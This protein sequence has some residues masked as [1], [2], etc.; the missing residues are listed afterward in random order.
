MQEYIRKHGKEL[1]K[2][3]TKGKPYFDLYDH[4]LFIYGIPK[5]MKYLSLIESHL[6]SGLVSWAGAVGP[7]QLMDEEAKR[8]GLRT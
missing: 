7:W 3:K 1:E 5:E 2:M 6:N 4:I 8:Y